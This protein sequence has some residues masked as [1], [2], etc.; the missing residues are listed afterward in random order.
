MQL[1]NFVAENYG[2]ILETDKINQTEFHSEFDYD[3]KLHDQPVVS[4]LNMVNFSI[5]LTMVVYPD[6]DKL[7]VERESYAIGD[8][9]FN[10]IL[11]NTEGTV[12]KEQAFSQIVFAT[13]KTTLD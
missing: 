3:R 8:V 5:P 10:A 7:D 11:T 4:G 9:T 6:F 13:L 1:E 12:V 2:N